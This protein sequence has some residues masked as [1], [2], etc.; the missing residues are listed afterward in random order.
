MRR[1]VVDDVKKA[2]G[3]IPVTHVVA[4]NDDPSTVEQ[5]VLVIANET[6]I[7]K[8]LLDRVRERAAKGP[9]S[10]LLV[11]PQSGDVESPEAARRL[12]RAIS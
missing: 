10:F 7:A 5:N 4:S 6:V 3:G 9:A 8:E 2:A 12:R 1:N 11:S